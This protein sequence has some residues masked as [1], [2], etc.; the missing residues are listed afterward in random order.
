M[1]D[2]EIIVVIGEEEEQEGVV[3]EGDVLKGKDGYTPV[4][5]VDYFDGVDGYTPVKGVDYWTE[6][7]VNEMQSYIATQIQTELGTLNDELELR[8]EGVE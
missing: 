7:D 8:L 1:N 3:V 5:G 2:E 6:E 4:K